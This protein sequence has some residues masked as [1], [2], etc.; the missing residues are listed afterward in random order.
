[1]RASGAALFL[2]FL[3][4]ACAA[5]SAGKNSLIQSVRR[6]CKA[7]HVSGVPDAVS[8]AA[9]FLENDVHTWIILTRKARRNHFGEITYLQKEDV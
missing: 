6:P 3:A 8:N 5:A 1:M 7:M 2:V 9:S 4:A